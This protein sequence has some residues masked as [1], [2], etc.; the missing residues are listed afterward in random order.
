MSTMPAFNPSIDNHAVNLSGSKPAAFRAMLQ[1]ADLEFIME[2]HNGLSARIC[3]E[4]GFK[5]IWASGLSISAALGVR[6]SN[7]ASWTQVLEVLEFMNDATSIPILVDGDTGHGNFN[8]MRRL[9]QKLEQ[10]GIAGV[11]IEDKLF[12]KTNSFL[13]SNQPLAGID[14]FCGKLKAGKDS[15]TNDDFSI[16]ARIEALIS[17]WGMDEA[18]KRADAYYKAGADALLI[19]SKISAPDEILE[20]CKEWANRCPVVIVPTMYYATPMDRFRAENVSLVIWANHNMRI[21]IQ[22]MRDVSR[23]I[24]E[25]ESLVNVEGLLPTVK[26]VF[27]LV[28]NAELAD[29]E[30]RYLPSTGRKISSVVLA[31][32]RG[33]AFGEL[34]ED[35]PKAMLDVRGQPLLRRLV[36]TINESG[37]NDITVVRG[38][39]KDVIDLPSLTYLDNEKYAETRSAA[40]LACAVDKLVGECVVTYGDILF[41][42]HV[43]N[44]LLERT[45][46]VVIVVDAQRR[47]DK[48]EKAELVRCTKP[49]DGDYF[50]DEVISLVEFADGSDDNVDGEFIGL[51]K[52]SEAGATA[53]QKTIRAMQADGSI[54]EALLSKLLERMRADGN[55]I[56]VHYVTGHWLD[57]DTAFDLAQARN[58]M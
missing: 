32:S 57:L 53:M 8:N 48:V 41:R 27:A 35:K 43:L 9:V 33:S 38:Y 39:K 45:E 14:E 37:L 23:Q 24:Y 3:E 4:T 15:Q 21:A 30:N 5:G 11:C 13:G 1:S 22:A 19:H 6:D 52:L 26:D 2:A 49:C 20:F 54:N 28:G 56:V 29:A 18:L 42:P 47:K 16:I 34:T 12:P 40:S 10:R 46:D 36:Q 25:E 51:L 44:G 17:G 50:D 55:E 7:E 31:A 58:V